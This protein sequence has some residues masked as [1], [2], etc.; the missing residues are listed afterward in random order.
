MA[1]GEESS[2]MA[3]HQRTSCALDIEHVKESL[4]KV[5]HL[6]DVASLNDP[7]DKPYQ[8]K[9]A[10]RE[11]LE[12]VRKNIDNYLESSYEQEPDEES[13]IICGN[14]L[15]N[16]SATDGVGT[17]AVEHLS[18]K[19]RLA[20]FLGYLDGRLG[21]NYIDCEETSTGD[22]LLSKALEKL[23]PLAAKSSPDICY[24]HMYL[25]N[26]LGVLY[27]GRRQHEK[28]E[29]ILREAE[30]VY[31]GY[32]GRFSDAPLMAMDLLHNSSY[33]QSEEYNKER[34]ENFEAEH[35]L[36]LYYL[37]QVIGPALPLLSS[38]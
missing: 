25:L 26:Q 21:S 2:G 17:E 14:S 30:K 38:A 15:P 10:A 9:Y 29:G 11:L 33:I 20:V 4:E 22:E 37:A 19:A 6:T 23:K 12:N 34:W 27:A 32:K 35:T 8:S 13:Q 16:E 24:V 1:S 18:A 28:A 7:D 36:T 3:N 5:N 31:L